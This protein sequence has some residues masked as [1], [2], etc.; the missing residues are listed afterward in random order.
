M[1]AGEQNKRSGMRMEGNEHWIRHHPKKVIALLHGI[2]AEDPR[3]Y[4][5]DFLAILQTDP[6]LKDYGLF[7]WKYPTHHKPGFLKNIASSA[8][9]NTL[10]E[11]AP[12]IP[13]LG[14][15]WETTYLTQVRGYDEIFLI[16][17]S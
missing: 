3:V 9:R 12:E 2:G 15:L 7:V 6:H 13:L 11:T 8:G 1:K 5:H 14:A 10:R 17:H 16:C 4:W